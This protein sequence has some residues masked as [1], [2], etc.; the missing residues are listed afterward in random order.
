MLM[1]MLLQQP[2][3]P[4]ITTAVA[5]V[6]KFEQFQ[7]YKVVA[8]LLAVFG[9][10]LIVVLDHT[11]EANPNEPVDDHNSASLLRWGK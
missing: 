5:V 3:F 2:I 11:S 8:I 7:W 9:T 1:C 10:V 6:L 4:I